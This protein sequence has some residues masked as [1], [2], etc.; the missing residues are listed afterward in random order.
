MRSLSGNRVR[1]GPVVDGGCLSKGNKRET[2]KRNCFPRSYHL[3]QNYYSNCHSKLKK[4]QWKS[5]P[6]NLVPLSSNQWGSIVKVEGLCLR[7]AARTG[8]RESHKHQQQFENKICNSWLGRQRAPLDLNSWPQHA[9]WKNIVAKTE[10]YSRCGND[11]WRLNYHPQER[12]RPDH[13]T[14][15]PI[16]SNWE[17]PCRSNQALFHVFEKRLSDTNNKLKC[18]NVETNVENTR[19]NATPTEVIRSVVEPANRILGYRQS[20]WV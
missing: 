14:D 20:P 16:W 4:N 18:G 15:I 5:N 9:H 8:H 11:A 17:Q 13:H 2:N 3:F 6:T 1:L 10:G 19:E 7:T 12:P